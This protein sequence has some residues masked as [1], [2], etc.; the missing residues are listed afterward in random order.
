[1]RDVR[2]GSIASVR[3]CCAYVRSYP[4]SDR[5][6]DLRARRLSANRRRR[7]V[8]LDNLVGAADERQ[9]EGNAKR[10]CGLEIDD[11]LDLHDLL[12]RQI[13]G[14]AALED[15]PRVEADLAVSIGQVAPIAHQAA[16]YREVA[17]SGDR[18]NRVAGTQG[19]DLGKVV[20]EV[21]I[22]VHD[23]RTG[24]ELHEAREGCVDLSCGACAQDV[25]L[26]PEGARGVLCRSR[27]GLDTRSLAEP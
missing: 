20:D 12:H 19:N 8:S 9:R 6:S 13:G 22:I 7:R 5:N 25:K 26:Y 11:H 2:F 16:G 15:F 1:M 3:V 17:P 10:L 21:A 4:D 27:I 18:R 24:S 14:L 23:Q